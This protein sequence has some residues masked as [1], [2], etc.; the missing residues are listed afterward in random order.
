MS[1]R[2]VALAVTALCLAGCDP[3]T[4]SV[5][6][7]NDCLAAVAVY[8]G[9]STQA[10]P[11]DPEQ[12][13]QWAHLIE[14]GGTVIPPGESQTFPLYE[15]APGYVVAY[16]PDGQAASI[17]WAE[18]TGGRSTVVLDDSATSAACEVAD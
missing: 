1:V 6:V 15:G 5:E 14:S 8:V 3:S 11:S 2:H 18:L 16:A 4:S 7:H 10:D 17:V 13:D 9:E 12:V